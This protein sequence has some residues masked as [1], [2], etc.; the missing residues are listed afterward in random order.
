MLKTFLIIISLEN[1][2]LEILKQKRKNSIFL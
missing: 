1:I 2:E